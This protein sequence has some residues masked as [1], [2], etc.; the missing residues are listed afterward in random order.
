MPIVFFNFNDIQIEIYY[1]KKLM[2]TLPTDSVGRFQDFV[3]SKEGKHSIK[4]VVK[5]TNVILDEMAFTS[6]KSQ[7]RFN[8]NLNVCGGFTKN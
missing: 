1:G 7:D 8:I 4:A 6:S 2:A 5:K 3:S